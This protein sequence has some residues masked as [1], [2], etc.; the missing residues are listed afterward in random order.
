MPLLSVIIPVYNEVSTLK[1]ILEKI[2]S[3][4]VDKEII[5]VDDGSSDG[6]V[7]LLSEIKGKGIK[8]I[9]SA[10]NRGK[11][12]AFLTGIEN[13]RGKFVIPQDA[14]LEYD[15]QDYVA[16]VDYALKNN[17]AVVYGSRFLKTWRVTSFWHYLVNQSLTAFTNILFGSSLTDMETC[18]KLVRLDLIKKLNLSSRRF[19]IEAEIT[20]K[21]LKQGYKIAEIPVSYKSR[22]YDQGKKIGWRDG[23]SSILCLLK[24]RLIRD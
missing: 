14:D 1:D 21:I 6:S 23:I 10:K 3:V 11:G 12:A 13:A 4:D 15:P 7:D 9:Y 22:F 2:C 24:L 17:L 20:A 8:I 16:L 19:E 5:V 18:Y